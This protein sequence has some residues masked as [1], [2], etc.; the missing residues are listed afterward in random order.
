MPTAGGLYYEEHGSGPPLILSSG[1]GGSANYWRPNIAALAEHF[2]VIG[3]DHRGTGRS[4]RTVTPRVESIGDDILVLMDSLGV[5]RASIVGHAIGGM[6]ALWLALH[7]PERIDRLVVV[8]GWGQLDPHT[9]RCFN[10]RLSLLRNV[11]VREY[12]HAQ[13]IFLYP[14]TW[15]SDHFGDL[16]DEEDVLVADFPVEMIDNRIV[17]TGQF[18]VDHITADLLAPTLF[19]AS[20]DDVLVPPTCSA[21]L[22]DRFP[23]AR[24]KAMNWGGHACNVTDPDTFNRI[25]LDFLRS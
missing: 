4:D 21:W 6:G 19:L 23:G 14:P 2:R 18:D 13:P 5:E 8:N 12:V 7:E 20:D 22:T 24:L 11:G 17:A 9:Y 16:D 25:V 3:Y 10:T 15:D 1:M